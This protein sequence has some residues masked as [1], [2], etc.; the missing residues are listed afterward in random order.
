MNLRKSFGYTPTSEEITRNAWNRVNRLQSSDKRLAKILGAALA[1]IERM[2]EYL[3][4]EVRR[5]TVDEVFLMRSEIVPW[6]ETTAKRIKVLATQEKSLA[7]AQGIL[8]DLGMMYF[9]YREQKTFSLPFDRFGAPYLNQYY[10]ADKLSEFAKKLLSMKRLE[11]KPLTDIGINEEDRKEAFS[12]LHGPLTL[13]HRE[14]FEA[15]D[16]YDH[17]DGC[18]FTFD[19]KKAIYFYEKSVGYRDAEDRIAELY[20][21]LG[22]Q[23]KTV[24][25]KLKN[26]TKAA[27]LGYTDPLLKLGNEMLK[28]AEKK[29]GLEAQGR[30][31]KTSKKK[32][33][34]SNAGLHLSE[35]QKKNT[36]SSHDQ[37]SL[38]KHV[39]FRRLP[40]GIDRGNLD[41]LK[42]SSP[43]DGSEELDDLRPSPSSSFSYEEG[44]K[45]TKGTEE[46]PDFDINIDNLFKPSA[47]TKNSNKEEGGGDDFFKPTAGSGDSVD[48]N[49]SYNHHYSGKYSSVEDL[50]GHGAS[51]GPGEDG[52]SQREEMRRAHER[53]EQL[54]FEREDRER[55]RAE[56]W[57]REQQRIIDDAIARQNQENASRGDGTCASANDSLNY[58]PSYDP[59]YNSPSFDPGGFY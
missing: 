44:E 6:A 42:N 53:E 57:Q 16:L 59:G 25:Q 19:A 41:D 28:K 23:S 38:P 7:L 3:S 1:E 17:P 47:W 21:Y 43:Y 46:A 35:K 2:Y 24:E 31:K 22:E 13:T 20:V 14:A 34:G 50:D 29:I 10:D 40:H 9:Y 32:K 8:N 51:W 58:N 55:E 37:G 18:W 12:R 27:E 15:G 56:Q 39:H 30:Q 5:A 52:I 33:G 11:H 54:R 45:G 36:D 26:F 48:P 49:Y 4:W